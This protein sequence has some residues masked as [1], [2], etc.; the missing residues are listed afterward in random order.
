M[1]PYRPYFREGFFASLVRK[2]EQ[3]IF[4]TE[5]C[6]Q[7]ARHPVHLRKIGNHSA[8]GHKDNQPVI[9]S[10]GIY[11]RF[12]FLPSTDFIKAGFYI[13]PF[14]D[15]FENADRRSRSVESHLC[16]GVSGYVT[17][18]EQRIENSRFQMNVWRDDH[19]LLFDGG[20]RLGGMVNQIVCVLALQ[21][22]VVKIVNKSG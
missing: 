17:D 9:V 16:A 22:T 18:P 10:Y 8:F 12:Q 7:Y 15:S 2:D 6:V 11:D 5:P 3:E 19:N 20:N 14:P 4:F 1:I 13:D 21:V